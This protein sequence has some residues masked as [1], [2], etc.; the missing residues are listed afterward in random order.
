MEGP[1]RLFELA[2]TYALLGD[3]DKT[4]EVLDQ[5]LAAN[6]GWMSVA[7]LEAGYQWDSLRD[8]PGYRALLEKYE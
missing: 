5:L 1:A 2:N 8:D 6:A 7:V 3:K 4:L